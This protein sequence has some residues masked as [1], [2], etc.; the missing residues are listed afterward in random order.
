MCPL[1]TP[2]PPGQTT[3]LP[4]WP[5]LGSPCT[6]PPSTQG[7][8]VFAEHQEVKIIRKWEK[9]KI[10]HSKQTGIC[11]GFSDPGES[12]Q[13]LE[14]SFAP[15]GR[16]QPPPGVG[17]HKSLWMELGWVRPSPS[18]SPGR[19]THSCDSS[20]PVGAKRGTPGICP[21]G[22]AST[23]AAAQTGGFQKNRSVFLL[24]LSH[25][26]LPP[27]ELQTVRSPGVGRSWAHTAGRP[28]RCARTHS[29]RPQRDRR[30]KNKSISFLSPYF[31]PCDK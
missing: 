20:V 11:P 10:N 26:Q 21:A 23:R 25:S 31:K 2:V 9:K 6:C 22:F 14:T 1:P 5:K 24:W 8:L 19:P 29:S 13:P 18:S 27:R 30:V 7:Q 4:V 16:R 15:H 28:P 12:E 3:P 17:G